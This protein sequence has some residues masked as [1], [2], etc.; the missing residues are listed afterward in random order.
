MGAQPRSC[1]PRATISWPAAINT[2]LYRSVL[3]PIHQLP[4]S[5]HAPGILYPARFAGETVWGSGSLNMC[6]AKA[7]A[8]F[9]PEVDVN[10]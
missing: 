10:R 9:W 1:H 7:H 3:I 2:L 8:R 6:G 5:L 4:I